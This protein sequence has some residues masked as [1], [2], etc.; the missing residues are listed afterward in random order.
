M[1]LLLVVIGVLMSRVRDPQMWAWLGLGP[2]SPPGQALPDIPRVD[3]AR[4][5]PPE[6]VD[7]D[8]WAAFQTDVQTVK[9]RQDMGPGDSPAYWR[10]IGWSRS[11]PFES[12]DAAARREMV[13]TQFWETPEDWRGELVHLELHVRRIISYEAGDNPENLETLYEAWGWTDESRQFPYAVVFDELPAGVS[14]GSDVR[15]E[16]IFAGFYLK[17]LS[18]QA[19]DAR[20][21]AP[22]FLGKV[23]R[24][25]LAP[26]PA[27]TQPPTNESSNWILLAAAG[28]VACSIILSL[29][30]LMGPRRQGR[31]QS[32]GRQDSTDPEQVSSWLSGLP[33]AGAPS[34]E[35]QD[36][37]GKNQI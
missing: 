19:G 35:E 20:R 25:P 31:A 17:N 14:L 23:I 34:P 24:N 12:L 16:L 4:G 27:A 5:T 8:Q 37:G 15:E 36:P 13:F 26:T 18:Y 22:L 7:A 21:A 6:F 1:L 30:R 28:V 29:R 9:D 33:A 2:S 11:Q 3:R 10:L 32:S